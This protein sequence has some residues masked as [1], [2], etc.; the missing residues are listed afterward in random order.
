MPLSPPA[1]NNLVPYD[2]LYQQETTRFMLALMGDS[3]C[4][5]CSGP[6]GVGSLT[7]VLIQEA[8]TLPDG[9]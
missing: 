5:F 1:C 6:H 8:Q 4:L 7:V 3:Q 9:A 2:M